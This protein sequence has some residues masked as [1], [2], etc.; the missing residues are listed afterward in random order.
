MNVKRLFGEPLVHFF[1]LGAGLFVL[2]AYLN[3]GA[4]VDDNEI[5]VDEALLSH[6]VSR[7]ER[8]WQRPPTEEEFQ[9]VVD[10]WIRDEVLYREGI[11][12]GLDVD[13]PIVRRRIAQKVDVFAETLAPY[14]ATDEELEQWLADNMSLYQVPPRFSLRQVFFD[15]EQHGGRIDDVIATALTRLANDPE[16]VGGDVTMLPERLAEVDSRQV[17]RTFGMEFAEAL[18]SA[19][20]GEWFGPIRS[21]FG[22]HLVLIDDFEEGR[23]PP[24]AE[25][26]ANVERDFLAARIT[27]TKDAFYE[28]LRKRYDVRIE[29]DA[30]EA[31]ES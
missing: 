2:F 9:G 28:E 23:E 13:D 20:P 14:S 4:A 11:A 25:V 29:R 6:L 7:F 31:G 24:L 17:S 22:L 5:V 1:L 16:Q 21:G 18:E 19:T 12:M 15:P 30:S 8:T 26:R 10:A 27:E 3:R